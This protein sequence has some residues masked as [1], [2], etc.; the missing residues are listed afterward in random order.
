MYLKIL[1]FISDLCVGGCTFQ[2]EKSS[3][4]WII[5]DV[6]G[7]KIGQI[8]KEGSNTVIQVTFRSESMPPIPQKIEVQPKTKE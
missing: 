4:A 7:E 3:S 2:E 6:D 8:I 5:F 1:S